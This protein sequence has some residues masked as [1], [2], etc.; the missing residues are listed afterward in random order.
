VPKSDVDTVHGDC[1][2]SVSDVSVL[3]V[4][5]HTSAATDAID[6]NVLV[7]LVHTNEGI[8]VI[9][10]PRDDDAVPM[11]ALT[12]D[13]TAA[14]SAS[15]LALI[16]AVFDE[17]TFPIDVEAVVRSDSRAREPEVRVP[18]VRLRVA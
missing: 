9:S 7:P 16:L 5:L 2:E 1:D 15:V 3:D 13:V 18:S 8:D 11:V 10:D 6:V 14:V 4:A 12:A 17:I